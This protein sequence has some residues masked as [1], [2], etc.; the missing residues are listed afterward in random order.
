MVHVPS[1]KAA[2]ILGLHPNTLR[3]YAD[4]GKIPHYRN[5]AGQRLYDVDSYLQGNQ[6][7][8]T[9]CYCRVSSHK[10]KDDLQRQVQFMHQ[11]YPAASIITDVG[12]GLNFQ[13][14]GLVSLL[15]RLHRGDKLTIVVAHRD[16]L[17]RFGFELIEWMAEAE[18]RQHP[19]SREP[20]SQPPTGTHRGYSPPSS[21]PSA[22][23]STDSAATETKS[24]RIR[25]YPNRQQRQTLKLWLDAARW[26][27]N[28]TIAYLRQPGTK[29]NWK[30]IKTAIINSAP[31]RLK[32]APYQVKSVAV[33]DA[34]RAVSSCKKA[35]AELAQARS[36]GERLDEPFARGRLPKPQAPQ[37]GLLHTLALHHN[38]GTFIPGCWA[39]C[40]WPKPCPPTTGTVV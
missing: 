16:R 3:S 9:V 36:C 11:R 22:A 1:R 30:N 21:I 14:K 7:P 24:R 2:E 13:R 32:A 4:Q 33:R 27:Y 38:G 18:R 20:G 12:G 6:E 10:Q 34:C 26:C 17:A 5:A 29:A 40:T 8:E 25:L 15:E 28:Q 37:T 23:D 31:E 35:N 39:N 19:G